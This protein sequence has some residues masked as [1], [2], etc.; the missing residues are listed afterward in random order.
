[1]LMKYKD[2]KML[3]IDDMNQIMGGNEPELVETCGTCPSSSGGGVKLSCIL[4]NDF[5]IKPANCNN[6]VDCK[7]D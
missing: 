6:A 3:S 4:K 5:C 7:K 2:F 1:M